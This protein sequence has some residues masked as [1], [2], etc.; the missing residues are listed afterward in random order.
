[1]TP[2]PG[3]GA[4]AALG[5]VRLYRSLRAGRPSPCRF[6]PSCST[7]TLEALETHGLLGG[8][9]LTARRLS[10]CHPF[11]GHGFDPVPPARAPIPAGAHPR[12]A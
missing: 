7:Y 4:R 12:K 9:W 3:I 6:D 8:S 1:M 5:L 11:G 2:S 10:R